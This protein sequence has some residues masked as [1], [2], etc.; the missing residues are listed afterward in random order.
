MPI[1]HKMLRS[2]YYYILLIT[3]LSASFLNTGLI[4]IGT[5]L[6][7]VGFIRYN[8]KVTRRCHV[9]IKIFHKIF[10]DM[11]IIHLHTKYHTPSCSGS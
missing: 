3:R 6:D 4:P 5:H 11:L 8:L 10:V 1:F 9:C 2:I 7:C